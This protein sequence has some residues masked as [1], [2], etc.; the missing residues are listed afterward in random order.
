MELYLRGQLAKAS[1]TNLE[2]IRFYENKQLIP[3][4]NR[5]EKGYRLYPEETL[6]RLQFIK[7]ARECGFSLVEIQSIIPVDNRNR[8]DR[9]ELKAL[10]TKKINE[11]NNI[12][13]KTEKMKTLLIGIQTEFETPTCPEFRQVAKDIMKIDL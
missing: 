6:I 4:P 1:D 7:L 3:P 5:T 9:D 11:I 13:I 10:L 12:L 2:T 8:L